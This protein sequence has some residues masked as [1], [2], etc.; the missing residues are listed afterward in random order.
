MLDSKQYWDALSTG[1]RTLAIAEGPETL[2]VSTADRRTGRSVFVKGS[3]NTS[4]LEKAVA[5]AGISA[6]AGTIIDVGAGYGARSIS[7]VGR[8]VFSRALA[9]EP[10]PTMFRLLRANVALNDA[11]DKVTCLNV[12]LAPTAETEIAISTSFKNPADAKTVPPESASAVLP[13][14]MTLDDVAPGISGES[15]LIVLD[16]AG[17]EGSVL[18]GASSAI[19]AGTPVLFRFSPLLTSRYDCF[20]GIQSLLAAH[21]GWYDLGTAEP[22]RQSGGYLSDMYRTTVDAQATA[23]LEILVSAA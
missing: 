18:A 2:I 14:V 20:A 12:A 3:V 1:A 9:I 5:L 4:S 8:G 16:V 17:Y 22:E 10:S 23:S 21:G 13:T 11:D 19:A 15:D 6:S 7:A